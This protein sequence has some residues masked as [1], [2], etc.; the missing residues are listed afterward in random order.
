MGFVR[1]RKEKCER[2]SVERNDLDLLG[3]QVQVIFDNLPTS[4]EY[5]RSGRLWPLAVTTARR[6]EALP[7]IPALGELVPGYE[8]TSWW[9][10]GA[11]KNTPAEIVDRLNKE[12]NAGL[13]DPKIKA[14]L[15]DLGLTVLAG[16]PSEFGK[17]M[18]E[19]IEK[20]AKVVK[21]SGAKAD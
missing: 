3:G 5:I 2:T 4:I 16:S 10:V 1:C 19:E 11:P 20:W 14:R 18:A 15:V 17:F 7:D 8:A 9:G 6:S 21:F 13:A 12:I